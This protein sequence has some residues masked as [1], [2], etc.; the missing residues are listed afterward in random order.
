M[1]HQ[2]WLNR[3]KPIDGIYGAMLLIPYERA[4]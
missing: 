2:F 1:S 3:A 4:C